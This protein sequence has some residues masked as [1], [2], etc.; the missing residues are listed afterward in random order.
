MNTQQTIKRGAPSAAPAGLAGFAG[1]ILAGAVALLLIS[2]AFGP[3]AWAIVGGQL[4]TNDT[5]SNVGAVVFAPP[6][7]VPNPRF[8][9]TLIHPRV[10]LTCAHT[11]LQFEQNH[12]APFKDC[13]VTFASDVRH[14]DK[15]ISRDI[16]A[17]IAHPD[18]QPNRALGYEPQR[19]DVGVIILKEPIYDLP[20]PRLAE[21]GFLDELRAEGLLRQPGQGGA[22]FTVVGYG[23]TIDWPPPEETPGDGPR[24]FAQTEFLALTQGWLYTAQNLATGSG[25]TGLGDSGGPTFWVN[26]DGSLV[27]VALTSGGNL[28]LIGTNIPWRVDIPETR[29]FINWV[30]N[31]VLPSLP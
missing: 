2:A 29:D 10:F 31:T 20:L 22:S 23:S 7:S 26:N 11:V 21:E 18:Y 27:L 25:G 8:T 28:R 6:G 17:V 1:R 12:P 3:R 5:Y 19:N 16:E 24:R 15:S 14:P 30:I 13:Y 9:G 4:D